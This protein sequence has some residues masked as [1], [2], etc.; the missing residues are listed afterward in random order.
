MAQ[1]SPNETYRI[2]RRC[3]QASKCPLEPVHIRLQDAHHLWHQAAACYS[4][5]D[6]FRIHLN[7][8]IQALRS[9]TWV[10]QKNKSKVPDFKSWYSKWQGR[11]KNDPVMRWLVRARN[12]IVKEGDLETLSTVHVSVLDS[13]NAPPF[14][15]YE[16][17]PMLSTEEIATRIR[18]ENLPESVRSEGILVV[19]RRWIEQDLRGH[20]LLDALAHGY[21]VLS[22]LMDDAHVQAGMP[23]MEVFERDQHGKLHALHIP[24]DQLGGR[25]PCMVATAEDRTVRMKLASLDIMTPMSVEFNATREFVDAAKARYGSPARFQRKLAQAKSLDEEAGILFDLARKVFLKD[26]Y[27]H[28]LVHLKLPG[29]GYRLTNLVIHDRSERYIQWNRIAASVEKTGAC[30]VISISEAWIAPFDPNH[31]ERPV[32]ESPDRKEVLGLTA[33]EENGNE[34][35]FIAEIIRKADAVALGR[36]ERDVKGRSFFL[37][38]VRRVW[39]RRKKPR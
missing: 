15:E 7:G 16:I 38:P 17:D 2:T 34:F 39:E 11:M 24:R 33:A 4:D 9:V 37:E 27:H 35:S 8:C 14:S 10:L 30:A 22:L 28:H 29:G 36:T 25:L 12:R 31:P 1:S 3:G 6:M 23:R 21:G 32:S 13:Y 18:L 20:E 26:G 5:P 19:E